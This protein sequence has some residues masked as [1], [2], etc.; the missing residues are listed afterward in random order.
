LNLEG[1][2]T[3]LLAWFV[4]G[5]SFDVRVALGMGLI[6]VGGICQTWMGRPEAGVRWRALAI[7]GASFA[8]AVNNNLTRKVSASDPVQIAK[9]KRLM[10]GSVTT[11][12]GLALG[13]KLP[14]VSAMLAVGVIGLCGYG[15]SLTLFILAP[16]SDDSSS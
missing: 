12:L 8:W 1:V 13:A 14:G 11:A 3:A 2:L 7:A 5:E 9:L 10:A 4:F 15:L 16:S 6:A